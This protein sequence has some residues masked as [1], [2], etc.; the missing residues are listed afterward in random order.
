MARYLADSLILP[1]DVTA[2]GNA[3]VD[4][5]ENLKEEFGEVMSNNSISLG[6]SL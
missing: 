4:Y 5:V 2:Y 6:K 1:L 3:M